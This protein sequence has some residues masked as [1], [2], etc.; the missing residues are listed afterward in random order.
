MKKHQIV[1]NKSFT[2]KVFFLIYLHKTNY[3]LEIHCSRAPIY[4]TLCIEIWDL[5]ITVLKFNRLFLIIIKY[6]NNIESSFSR[7]LTIG[8][9]CYRY[10]EIRSVINCYIL[11]LYRLSIF[12]YICSLVFKQAQTSGIKVFVLGLVAQ[13]RGPE[14]DDKM[15]DSAVLLFIIIMKSSER[16]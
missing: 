5:F 16:Y 3:V 6:L 2:F 12:T 8:C 11:E 15:Y 13:D 14:V 7:K 10:T 4:N 9:Y 1:Q